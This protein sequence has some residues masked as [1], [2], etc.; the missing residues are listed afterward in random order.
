MLPVQ[1]AGNAPIF[2]STANTVTS[3]SATSTG[4]RSVTTVKILTHG[5]SVPPP[6]AGSKSEPTPRPD[7]LSP[8]AW[9]VPGKKQPAGSND[10]VKAS[11]K[12]VRA[13]PTCCLPAPRG[14]VALTNILSIPGNNGSIQDFTR[15]LFLPCVSPVTLAG[16]S[17]RVVLRSFQGCGPQG[18]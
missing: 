15:A 17:L 18:K 16:S 11:G 10:Q 4:S 7:D 5:R 3:I 8:R 6:Q 12:A 13:A 2:P 1:S 14:G 9:A